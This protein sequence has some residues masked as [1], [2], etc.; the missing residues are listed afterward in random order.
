MP[1]LIFFCNSNIF[2]NIY[3]LNFFWIYI[4]N[5]NYKL[6]EYKVNNYTN[7]INENLY[8]DSQ[9]FK[10]SQIKIRYNKFKENLCI[11]YDTKVDSCSSCW[12]FNF[13]RIWC[14]PNYYLDRFVISFEPHLFSAVILLLFVTYNIFLLIQ[15]WIL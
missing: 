13:Q 6:S 2:V 15:V 4:Y 7:K 3:L 8:A 10:R 14:N 11:C 1:C 5:F 9:R 12:K